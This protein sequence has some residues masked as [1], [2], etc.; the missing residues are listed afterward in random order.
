MALIDLKTDFRSLKFGLG[1]AS[2]K[3]GGGYSNQPY[4]VK[5]IPDYD[6]DAS[7]I[8][9]T[10]GPDSLLRG[11]LMAPIKAIDDVS[12]LTK[13]FFDLKSPNGL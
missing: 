4:V 7:N 8:F 3:P 10:G 1:Q 5:P 13:M 6:E 9:N 12:R 11:G 2:D